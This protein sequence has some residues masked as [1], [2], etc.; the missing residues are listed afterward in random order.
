MD[1]VVDG[2]YGEVWNLVGLEI[3]STKSFTD[4]QSDASQHDLQWI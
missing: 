3:S 2:S 1:L 4:I